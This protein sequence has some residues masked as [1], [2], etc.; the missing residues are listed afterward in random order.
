MLD[1]L[2]IKNIKPHQKDIDRVDDYSFYKK[3]Y[4]NWFYGNGAPISSNATK[5]A[6]LIKDP[7]KLIR[8]AKAV[9]ARWGTGDYH[10]YSAGQPIKEN[11]WNPFEQALKNAG[12]DTLSIEEI[13]D[14]SEE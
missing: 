13:K 12:F 4:S 2:T 14:Y 3:G 11:V 8:R 1:L 6:K 5:Q 10:G 7:V 9:I